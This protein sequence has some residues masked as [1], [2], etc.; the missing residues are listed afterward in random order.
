MQR[1]WASTESIQ[2]GPALHSP[3]S[4]ATF[5]SV[6]PDSKL[7]THLDIKSP[8]MLDS[9]K[10]TSKEAAKQCFGNHVHCRGITL[11]ELSRVRVRNARLRI[12][13]FPT[14]NYHLYELY[15]TKNTWS[16]SFSQPNS[17]CPSNMLIKSTLVV[18]F[19]DQYKIFHT[20]I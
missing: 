11:K 2:P 1:V 16:K 4:P 6:K 7:F 15:P 8:K 10:L 20:Q 3:G 18:I 12:F 17:R 14:D 5:M 9:S 19:S 13:V